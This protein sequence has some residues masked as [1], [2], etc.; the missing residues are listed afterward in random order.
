MK[1]RA[2]V[3][4]LICVLIA[5]F[6]VVLEEP[7]GATTAPTGPPAGTQLCNGG[8]DSPE[9][10]GP[11]TAPPGSVTVPAGN[12][13]SL[14]LR[15]NTTY[16]L[17]SGT[18]T[19]GT[20]E[21]GQWQPASGDTF[22]GAPGAVISG[23]NINDSA[24]DLTA[25]NVTIEYLTIENFVAPNGQMVVN[26]NGGA[27]WTIAYDSII[28]NGGA[29]VGVGSGDVVEHDCLSANDEYGFSSF[30]GATNVT[31]SDNE[32][33]YND[34]N[35]TYD[36]GAY[37]T[38][39]S[40]TSDVATI[41]TEAPMYLKVGNPIIVGGGCS[42]GWCTNLSRAAL[43]G[44]WT[45]AS[46]PSTTSFTFHVTTANV[47]T[48]SDPS[49]TV[50]DPQVTCGCAGGGKF[51]NTAGATVADNWV[52]GNGDVGIWVDTDNSGFDISDN[53]IASNWAEGI[54]YEISYNAD[55][56]DNTLIDNAWGGG[57]SPG[58]GGFP[59]PALYIS[60]S[61]SD[62]RVAGNYG[63]MFNVSGNGFVDNWGGIVIYENSNRACGI[64]NDQYC[65]L[66]GP[67]TY[68]MSSCAAHIPN[69]STTATPDYVDNCRWKSEN[70]SVDDN[71]FDFTPSD[72]GADC[73]T[74][75]FCGY[76]G[77]F[78]E[79]GTTP[80]STHNGAWPSGA[81]YPYGGYAV[82]NNISNNQHNAYADNTYCAG[83]GA[84]WNFVAFAQGNGVSKGSWTGGL[85]NVLGTGDKFT[86]QDAG[87][88][89]SSTACP[90]ADPPPP[91]PPPTVTSIT[92]TSGPAAGGT[93]VTIAG[94][95]LSSVIAVDFGLDA[96][97]ITADSATS[98]TATSPAG[99]G[100][101]DVT[102]TTPGGTSSTSAADVF[103]YVA[104]PGFH[105]VTTS[106]PTATRGA[107]YSA[108]LSAADGVPPYRWRKLTP[109]PHGLRLIGS[110]GTITGTPKS[111]DIPGTYH[112]TIGVFEHT[113]PKQMVST[114][115]I[116]SLN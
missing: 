4:T 36:E 92:P 93:S 107:A 37:V 111:K 83:G 97:T 7:A 82:P 62:S 10:T 80:G 75:I 88:T 11:S 1:K 90:T 8:A 101:V 76:N 61:G 5:G 20:S 87:S 114:T 42:T 110:T 57:P 89:F 31:L 14:A 51:W 74:S 77:L 115:L 38:S 70:V 95:N 16:Y 15:A 108:T 98:I 18:H 66:A 81:S 26:H 104:P 50:A 106:L 72:I 63:P 68:T 47:G 100:A 6:G 65:T 116:L 49:G 71:V 53:Y 35:G 55:I 67:G 23:Q 29:G 109:L 44:T 102:A 25:S 52:H 85:T 64:S 43:N 54:I 84:A 99:S 33:S 60:E 56:T 112:I 103:T 32:I 59:D 113:R 73:T 24:F 28:H 45:I 3:S 12:N 9:L 21:F 105:N 27:N 86:A 19:L 48:T 34:T 94:T 96:A 41:N 13:G 46:I 22:I 2:S 40:V 58:L 39:Y 17:A 79:P 69:G 91:P 30:G 78:S